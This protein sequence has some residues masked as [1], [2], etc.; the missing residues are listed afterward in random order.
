MYLG[1]N[2][3]IVGHIHNYSE[4]IDRFLKEKLNQIPPDRF[5]MSSHPVFYGVDAIEGDHRCSI[6]KAVIETELSDLKTGLISEW[7]ENPK[8]YSY[9]YKMLKE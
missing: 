6:I 1:I 9:V 7:N 8:I 5:V 2:A 3:R 4:V